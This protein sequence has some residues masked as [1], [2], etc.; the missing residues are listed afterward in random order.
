MFLA[1]A[2]NR[3][4]V[5]IVIILYRVVQNLTHAPNFMTSWLRYV[6]TYFRNSFNDIVIV[7]LKITPKWNASEEIL[8]IVHFGKLMQLREK[9][10][11]LTLLGC[12]SSIKPTKSCTTH[13]FYSVEIRE[14]SSFV[15]TIV[16]LAWGVCKIWAKLETVTTKIL[17]FLRIVEFF[18]CIKELVDFSR[19]VAR[20]CYYFRYQS[21]T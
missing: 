19:T 14:I 21:I 15:I 3:S 11:W 12:V 9:H 8:K 2:W 5:N 20:R 6:L 1:C 13:H 18:S 16:L 4:A 17:F 10:S 7:G